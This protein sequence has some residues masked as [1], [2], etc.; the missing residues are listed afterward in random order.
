MVT[1]ADVARAGVLAAIAEYD[2]LG[3]HAFL[4]QTGF[5]PANAYFLQH[6]GR[7]YDSKAI[8]GYAHGVSTGT[9]LGPRDFSGG[10]NTVVPR[11]Q[12]LGFTVRY[13]A[14]LVS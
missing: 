3:R 10:E 6:D 1:L 7:L 4:R 9:P 8:V 11:L 14:W 13:L 12:G 2:R 5:G